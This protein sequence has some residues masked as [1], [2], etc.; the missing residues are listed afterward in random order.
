[1]CWQ[2]TYDPVPRRPLH[3]TKKPNDFVWIRNNRFSFLFPDWH[4]WANALRRPVVKDTSFQ[5]LFTAT[6]Q[7][8]VDKMRSVSNN[9]F[10][11]T[12]YPRT[13][14]S[15]YFPFRRWLCVRAHRKFHTTDVPLIVCCLSHPIIFFVCPVCASW[16]C[17]YE[18]VYNNIFGFSRVIYHTSDLTRSY[19]IFILNR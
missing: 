14:K 3:I 7:I 8:F 12:F 9:V 1:M 11:Y 16:I 6:V 5:G 18:Y 2:P 4:R 15:V 17:E 13:H 19:L 10:S